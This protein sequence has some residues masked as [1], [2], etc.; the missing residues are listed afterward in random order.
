MIYIGFLVVVIVQQPPQPEPDEVVPEV[1]KSEPELSGGSGDFRAYCKQCGWRNTYPTYR[2]SR[3]GLGVHRY[4]C[5]RRGF[6]R[7]IFGNL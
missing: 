3:Q 7:S 6:R 1:E 5:K 4:W 2:Q